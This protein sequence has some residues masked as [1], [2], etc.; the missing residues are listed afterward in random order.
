MLDFAV[1][2][3]RSQVGTARFRLNGFAW[4]D[5]RCVLKNILGADCKADKQSMITVDLVDDSPFHLVGSFPGPSDTPYEGGHYEVVCI[6]H[7]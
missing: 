5:R 2:T 3:R 1:S 6:Y 4:A 7:R